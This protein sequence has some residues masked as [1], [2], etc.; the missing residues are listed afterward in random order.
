MLADFRPNYALHD[1]SVLR[2]YS[3]HSSKRF[4]GLATQWLA[5]GPPPASSSLPQDAGH[6]ADSE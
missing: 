4:F 1:V 5:G 6:S 3:M 2:G